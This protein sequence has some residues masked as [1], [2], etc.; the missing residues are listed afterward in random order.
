MDT[1]AESEHQLGVRTIYGITRG[2]LLATFLQEG[3]TVFQIGP[4]GRFEHR[5]N[6]TDRNVDINIRGAVERIKNQQVFTLRVAIGDAEGQIHFFRRHGGEVAAPF[7]GIKQNFV[8][9]DIQLLLDFT[10][11]VIR[12]GAAH[13]IAK[14]ALTNCDGNSFT[15]TRNDFDQQAQIGVKIIVRALLFDQKAGQRNTHDD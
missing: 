7:V 2:D 15:G 13:G 1:V 6:G 14:V 12:S 9:D 8:G 11:H 5:E 4:F 10:L 3:V